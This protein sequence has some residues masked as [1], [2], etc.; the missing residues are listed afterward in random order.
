VLGSSDS[1]IFLLF[2]RSFFTLVLVASLIAFP[3]AWFLVKQWLA[4]FAYQVKIDFG[5]FVIAGLFAAV[6]AFITVC[7]QAFRTANTNPAQV[8]KNE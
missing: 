6:V 7:Y 3:L 1:Q 2:S 5:L 4:G 8:L